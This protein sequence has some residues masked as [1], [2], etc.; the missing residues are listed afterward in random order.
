MYALS[1]TTSRQ[2]GGT[3]QAKSCTVPIFVPLRLCTVPAFVVPSRRLLY[4]PDVCNC[5]VP[6]I[7]HAVPKY[8][9][10]DPAWTNRDYRVICN[11]RVHLHNLWESSIFCV[12]PKACVYVEV[13]EVSGWPGANMISREPH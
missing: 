7:P 10:R 1:R 11:H 6:Y 8:A 4:R 12:L 13:Y 2:Q 9:A 3:V 5:T